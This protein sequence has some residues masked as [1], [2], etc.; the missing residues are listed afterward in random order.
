MVYSVGW[1]VMTETIVI[2]NVLFLFWF[3]L[4]LIEANK[5]LSRSLVNSHFS[6]WCNNNVTYMY[7]Q[8]GPS[9]M[10]FFGT[11]GDF[12][13]LQAPYTRIRRFSDL[14]LASLVISK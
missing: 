2:V 6:N 1:T 11:S 14:L 5:E 12:L 3:C 13:N 9:M 7:L 10:W 4:F 8:G